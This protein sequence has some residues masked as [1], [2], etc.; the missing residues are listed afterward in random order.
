MQGR[1]VGGGNINKRPEKKRK[2]RPVEDAAPQD[3]GLNART[4]GMHGPL[5]FSNQ[6]CHSLRRCRQRDIALEQKVKVTALAAE[7]QTKENYKGE[8]KNTALENKSWWLHLQQK[9]NKK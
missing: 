9:S 6:F 7:I 3:E 4:Q 1:S 5:H 8:Q 2:K